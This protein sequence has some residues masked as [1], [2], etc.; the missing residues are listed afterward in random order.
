MKILAEINTSPTS[1]LQSRERRTNER[2]LTLFLQT[3]MTYNNK[4]KTWI[5]DHK[6]PFFSLSIFKKIKKTVIM[7]SAPTM[8]SLLSGV[9]Q[10]KGSEVAPTMSSLLSR[11]VR[12]SKVELREEIQAPTVSSMISNVLKTTE[13]EMERIVQNCKKKSEDEG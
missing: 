4:Q 12:E 8:S 5:S 1:N 13:D 9:S 2:S 3:T 11:A 10:S 7:A 6:N